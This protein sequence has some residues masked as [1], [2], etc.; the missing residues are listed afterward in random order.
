M[1]KNL[2]S[3]VVPVYNKGR[4]LNQCFQSLL[5]QTYDN[6]EIVA[7][8]D[9]STDDGPAICETWAG[10]DSRIKVIHQKN[11]GVSAAR[12]VGVA[13]SQGEWITFVDADDSLPVNAIA[14]LAGNMCDCDIIVGQVDFNG[15][16]EW[17]YPQMDCFLS[18]RKYLSSLF[19]KKI[20][21]GPVAKLFKRDLF[22]GDVFALPRS[23]VCGE[24]FLMNIRIAKYASNVR[25]VK[26]TVYLY[27]YEEGSAMAKMPF[28]SFTYTA[29]F[30]WLT[31]KSLEKRIS[32]VP[33]IISFCKRMCFFCVKKKIQSILRK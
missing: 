22:Q 6:I 17:P 9:G 29:L 1:K 30:V 31:I 26:D 14:T 13:E 10:R 21:S 20:H 3:I 7:V 23:V 24:D 28:A 15:P 16:Y 5:L 19:Y 25:I 4:F 18:K 12:S 2:I 11:A 33:L 27:K 32:S 8:D